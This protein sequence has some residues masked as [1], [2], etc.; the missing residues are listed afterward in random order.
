V[1]AFYRFR[2]N[3][4]IAITPGVFVLFNPEGNSANNTQYVGVVRTTFT[5]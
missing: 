1:E 2:I 4:N 5:F 3:D